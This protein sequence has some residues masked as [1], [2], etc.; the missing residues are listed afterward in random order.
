[1]TRT[2]PFVVSVIEVQRALGTQRADEV[3]GQLGGL[4]ITDAEV[5]PTADIVADVLLES[6]AGN[7]VTVTGSLRAPYRA[8]C[9]R[10]LGPVEGQ[11]EVDLREV[12]EAHPVEGETYLLTRDWL[13]LEPMVRDALVL[14]LPVAPLC[15]PDCPGPDPGSFPVTVEEGPGD[16]GPG[17][18]AAA[19]DAAE[20]GATRDPR[21]AALDGLRLD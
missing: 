7:E 9:R 13:D 18:H 12:F 8:T 14:A 16:P 15:G 3:H 21:W 11:L 20:S 17:S 1:M 2:G 10:C 6:T 4:A 5:P 19:D